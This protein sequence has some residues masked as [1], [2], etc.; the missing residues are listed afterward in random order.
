[1]SATE[2]VSYSGESLLKISDVIARTTLGR[3]SIHRKVKDGE[4][5]A[6]VMIG[7]KMTRWLKSDIDKW[8]AGLK[9]EAA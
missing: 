5:P 7:P 6:P 1:M 4:F 3:T 2:A 8:I 9:N